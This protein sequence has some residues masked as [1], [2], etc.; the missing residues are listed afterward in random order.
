[1]AKKR[2]FLLLVPSTNGLGHVRRLIHL[3]KQWDEFQQIVVLLTAKQHKLIEVELQSILGKNFDTRILLYLG[4]GVDGHKQIHS[5]R[6]FKVVSHDIQE[7]LNQAEMV[8]SDN[9]IWPLYFRPDCILVGHFLWHDLIDTRQL[10]ESQ[11]LRDLIFAEKQLLENVKYVIGIENFSFGVLNS[12]T[13]DKR[14]LLPSYYEPKAGLETDNSIWYALGTTGLGAEESKILAN[15]EVVRRESYNLLHATKLPIAIVG[16]PGL[17]TVRDAIEFEVP[18][19]PIDYTSDSELLNNSQ[20][21]FEYHHK[22]FKIEIGDQFLNAF[23]F[24]KGRFIGTPS[25]G[26]FTNRLY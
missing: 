21:I 2:N 8:I 20:V 5:P 19:S 22:K 16:R 26:E 12:M 10:M 15:R 23:T 11:V 7:A 6:E 3:V 13:P 25:L 1:M 17:G 18:F 14:I 9:C 24:D 4:Y